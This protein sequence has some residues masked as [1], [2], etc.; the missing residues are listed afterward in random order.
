LSLKDR[1][2]K[3]I[4]LIIDKLKMIE[5]ILL[6]IG[7]VLLVKS[8]D[9]IVEGSAAL[10]KKFGISTLVIGLTVV[11]FGTSF[12]ELVVNLVAAFKGNGDIAFGNIIGSSMSNTLLI[13]GIVSLISVLSVSK[14]TIYKE[15]PYSFFA[16]LVLLLFSF[17]IFNANSES[18][19]LS[20]FEGFILL[21]LFGFFMYYIFRLI[22]SDKKLK[23]ELEVDD[24]KSHS[25]LIIFVMIFGGLV[26]LYFGGEF[27]VNSAVSIAKNFG[28]SDFLISATII[29][30]GTSLPE[31]V[32]SIVA[33]FKNKLDLAVGNII[34][35][36]IF[37]VLWILGLTAL[38]KPVTFPDFI[39]IDLIILLFCTFLLFLFMFIGKKKQLDKYE[40][41]TFILLYISYIVYI[42]LRN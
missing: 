4:F 16:V 17:E 24:V 11:A 41:I 39:R 34:G 22:K 20:R 33:G 26:G 5:Y 21:I 27:T 19:I 3:N 37:N 6:I 28:M 31:L 40:G 32:T 35:S 1:F 23:K 29:A 30:I 9:Y 2:L 25:K 42:I 10:A 18:A 12:P 38:I 15:I 36:N 7:I 13:L 14:S 8:A